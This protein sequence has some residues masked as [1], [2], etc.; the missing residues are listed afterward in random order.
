MNQGYKT[1]IIDKDL[2]GLIK[3]QGLEENPIQ[4]HQEGAWCWCMTLRGLAYGSSADVPHQTSAIW[5]TLLDDWGISAAVPSRYNV[6]SFYPIAR[7]GP[8]RTTYI[9]NMMH[10]YMIACRNTVQ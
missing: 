1:L 8:T 10:T 4:R 6:T 3:Q 5:G 2:K 7:Y 9:L